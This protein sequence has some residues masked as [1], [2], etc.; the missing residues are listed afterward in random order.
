MLAGGKV[1]EQVTL[2]PFEIRLTRPRNCVPSVSISSAFLAEFATLAD[3][4][5][6]ADA[7]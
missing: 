6:Q 7:A 4:I 3:H 2:P 5:E 1:P